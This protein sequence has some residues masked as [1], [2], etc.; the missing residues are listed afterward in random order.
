VSYLKQDS[1]KIE[2]YVKSKNKKV[3]WNR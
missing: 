2:E 3:C 1:K